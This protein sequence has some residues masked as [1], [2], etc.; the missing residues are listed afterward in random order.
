[1]YNNIVHLYKKTGRIVKKKIFTM[2]EGVD[3]SASNGAIGLIMVP[4]SCCPNRGVFKNLIWAIVV[5]TKKGMD[6]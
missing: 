4:S 5:S 6:A 2:T 1:L 3:N